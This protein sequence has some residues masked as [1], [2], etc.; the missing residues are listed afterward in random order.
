M[1]L[2]HKFLSNMSMFM[3][4]ILI[5]KNFSIRIHV[6]YVRISFVGTSEIC[7]LGSRHIMH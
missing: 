5:I 3:G 2:E 4:G 1:T 6:D 7:A